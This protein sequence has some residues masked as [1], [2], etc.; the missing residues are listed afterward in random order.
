MLLRPSPVSQEQLI[1]GSKT[2][3]SLE[4]ESVEGLKNEELQEKLDVEKEEQK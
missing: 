2:E 1:T 4:M 3:L